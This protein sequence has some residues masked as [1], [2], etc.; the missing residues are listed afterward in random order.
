MNANES[1]EAREVA[2]HRAAGKFLLNKLRT[3]PPA[4]LA[5]A[6]RPEVA[7]RALASME[8]VLLKMTEGISLEDARAQVDRDDAT[9]D[10]IPMVEVF[11]PDDVAEFRAMEVESGAHQRKVLDHFRRGRDRALAD[12]KERAATEAQLDE[13]EAHAMRAI[14]Q[15][16]AA[17]AEYD[18]MLADPAGTC[19]TMVRKTG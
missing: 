3:A 9:D 4:S 19:W 12:A 8:S 13:I 16:A 11:D 7:A 5:N 14:A 17:V 18:Q 2:F 15:A 10:G 6:R 1:T